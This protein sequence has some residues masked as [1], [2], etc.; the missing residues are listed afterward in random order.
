M[1][2]L[3]GTPELGYFLRFSETVVFGLRLAV[4]GFTYRPVIAER[5]A[6]PVVFFVI[7][8]TSLSKLD[9]ASATV[10]GVRD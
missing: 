1:P 5:W 9:G 8:I 6:L 2:H 4:D 10:R 3:R 7:R